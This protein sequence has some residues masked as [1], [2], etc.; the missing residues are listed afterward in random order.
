[1]FIMSIKRI[2]EGEWEVIEEIALDDDSVITHTAKSYD[3]VVKIINEI[4]AA[5]HP[6]Q[7]K[8][9]EWFE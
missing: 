2:K 1:M 3:A 5:N 9:T 8:L 4:L 7:T 6:N